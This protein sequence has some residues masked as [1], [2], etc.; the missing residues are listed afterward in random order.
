MNIPTFSLCLE[1]YL[2]SPRYVVQD[3]QPHQSTLVHLTFVTVQTPV[4]LCTSEDHLCVV[5][6]VPLYALL[7]YSSTQMHSSTQWL[8]HSFRHV[9]RNT[10]IRSSTAPSSWQSTNQ[11]Q[12]VTK[13]QQTEAVGKLQRETPAQVRSPHGLQNRQHDGHHRTPGC[14]GT[15]QAFRNHQRKSRG[16]RN[17]NLWNPEVATCRTLPR[18]VR[19]GIMSF[20]QGK[21]M[22]CT[23]CRGPCLSQCQSRARRRRVPQGASLWLPVSGSGFMRKLRRGR[24]LEARF[25]IK[26]GFSGAACQLP[27]HFTYPRGVTGWC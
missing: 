9:R 6:V 14:L 2:G 4:R 17:C 18:T 19:Q 25:N 13:D 11:A 5:L 27:Y 12:A 23:C 16:D 7:L 1:P 26:K 10:L 24:K 3:H 20:L 8:K 21:R 22:R 15:D